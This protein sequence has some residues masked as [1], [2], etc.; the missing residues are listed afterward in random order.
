MCMLSMV[1]EHMHQRASQQ[2][3]IRQDSQQV[4]T[5]LG[6]EQETGYCEKT[7][8]HPT[9]PGVMRCFVLV[10]HGNLSKVK[11]GATAVRWLSLIPN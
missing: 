4:G 8:E 11:R 10:S 9:C 7:I 2:E 5:M 3:Q 1:H 6:K